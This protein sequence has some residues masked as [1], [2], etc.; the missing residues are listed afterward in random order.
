MNWTSRALLLLLTLVSTPLLAQP[1]AEMQPLAKTQATATVA[2][3]VQRVIADGTWHAALPALYAEQDYALAWTQ[4]GDARR[5]TEHV[6]AAAE[7]GA[8]ML[9]MT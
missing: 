2:D 5:L 9:R 6:R 4:A 3:R 1:L 7:P 8:G